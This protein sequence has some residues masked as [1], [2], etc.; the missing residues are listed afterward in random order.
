MQSFFADESTTHHHVG[1]AMACVGH[2]VAYRLPKGH[3]F[4]WLRVPG[5]KLHKDT[6]AGKIPQFIFTSFNSLQALWVTISV[7]ATL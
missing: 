5:T 2:T 3:W 4:S 1:S 6:A 7:L